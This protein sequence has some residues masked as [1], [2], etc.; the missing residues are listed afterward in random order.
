MNFPK[1]TLAIISER[2]LKRICSQGEF[3][4][5]VIKNMYVH[6]SMSLQSAYLIAPLGRIVGGVSKNYDPYI[7][8]RWKISDNVD[9]LVKDAKPKESIEHV[10]DMCK[11]FTDN[12]EIQ[13]D[14]KILIKLLLKYQ[15]H[16][17]SFLSKI[18]SEMKSK[19]RDIEV[20]IVE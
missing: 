15:K 9:F 16:M 11:L 4:F 18:R 6:K 7:Y 12:H 10:I 19:R 1:E 3:K 17:V 5:L 2:R 13:E 14:A 8:C 20:K